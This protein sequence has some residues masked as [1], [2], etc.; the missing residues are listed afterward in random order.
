MTA[1]AFAILYF[2]AQIVGN[3]KKKSEDAGPLPGRTS[4]P[5]PPLRQ[6][7]PSEPGRPPSS[8]ES[9]DDS[10]P[11]TLEPDWQPPRP[12]RR[13]PTPPRRV[14]PLSQRESR[15]G[16]SREGGVIPPRLPRGVG[17][18]PPRVP[19]VRPT[20]APARAATAEPPR[21]RPAAS[22]APSAAFERSSRQE[23]ALFTPSAGVSV[24]AVPD[25]RERSAYEMPE[26][27]A[28][29]HADHGAMTSRRASRGPALLGLDRFLGGR[30]GVRTSLVLSEILSA[31]VALRDDHLV[32]FP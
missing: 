15:P 1:A 17:S 8:H 27:E 13:P 14:E 29:E 16:V 26:H 4:R 24:D 2:A 12:P 7:S 25:E 28:H 3:L 11:A 9:D 23:P 30:A 10:I 5:I 19:P 22:S 20:P 32:R 21:T 31:P 18:I 6:H